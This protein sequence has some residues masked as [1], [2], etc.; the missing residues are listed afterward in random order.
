MATVISSSVSATGVR[1]I[2]TSNIITRPVPV[3]ASTPIVPIYANNPEQARAVLTDTPFVAV[4]PETMQVTNAGPV[5]TDTAVTAA[6]IPSAPI[7]DVSYNS[8][9]GDWIQANPMLA[10][11]AA[12]LVAY[13]IYLIAKKKRR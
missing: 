11:G 4:N 10:G 7:L 1:K 3:T 9:F 2:D 5:S 6:G 8:K 13:S 12:L